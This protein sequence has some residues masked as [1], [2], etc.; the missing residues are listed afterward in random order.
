MG[1]YCCIM[2][3]MKATH[4]RIAKTKLCVEKKPMIVNKV[5]NKT[6]QIDYIEDSIFITKH[7]CINCN[8]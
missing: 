8:E 1:K 6:T 7:L 2:R 5:A 4:V 3:S